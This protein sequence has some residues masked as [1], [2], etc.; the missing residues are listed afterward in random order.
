MRLLEALP[1]QMGLSGLEASD[2]MGQDL[3]R[4]YDSIVLSKTKQNDL[5]AIVW[6][7]LCSTFCR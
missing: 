7:S 5:N 6:C 1:E 4:L 2:G 3:C